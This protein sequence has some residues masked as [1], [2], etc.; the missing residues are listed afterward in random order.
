MNIQHVAVE[1]ASKRVA[2]LTL[3]ET[4]ITV[5]SCADSLDKTY[6]FVIHKFKEF[7]VNCSASGDGKL[8]LLYDHN[9]SPDC[10]A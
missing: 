6:I 5:S 1:E 7:K 2:A 9:K 4:V 3:L 10:T 8:K